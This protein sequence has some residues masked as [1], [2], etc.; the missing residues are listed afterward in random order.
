M[1]EPY[2]GRLL[3]KFITDWRQLEVGVSYWM[4]CR[5]DPDDR[6]II[7]VRVKSTSFRKG[8]DPTYLCIQMNDSVHWR[9]RENTHVFVAIDL[10]PQLPKE[11][12]YFSG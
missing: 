10:P 2:E 9:F 5:A 6:N 4:I 3:T 1:S 7:E 11:L 8:E 12:E